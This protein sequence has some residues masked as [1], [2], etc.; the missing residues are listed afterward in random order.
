MPIAT[1]TLTPD[2]VMNLHEDKLYEL[3]DGELREKY[4]GAESCWSANRIGRYLSVFLDEKSLGWVFTELSY[5]CFQDQPSLIRRPDVSF[6]K[7]GRFPGKPPAGHIP[8]A[9]DLAVEVVSP[10]DQVYDLD[11]KIIEYRKA[12]VR[13]IWVLNPDTR[14]VRVHYPNGSSTELRE[15]QVLAGEDVLP[16]FSC[17]VASLFMPE[18]TPMNVQ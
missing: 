16:G 11:R 9:P 12:G 6:I 1:E 14:R 13:L 3:V 15:G 10:N 17:P 5:K 8:I 4:M 7:Y 2:E 18:S